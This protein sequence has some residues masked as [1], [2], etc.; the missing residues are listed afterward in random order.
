MNRFVK[1]IEPS[2]IYREYLTSLNGLLR[3][4]E[5]ELDILAKIIELNPSSTDPEVYANV[6][7]LP[8]R[9]KVI[10]DAKVNK[11]NLSKHITNFTKRG[12]L[13]KDNITG[14]V[15]INKALVP[16]IENGVVTIQMIIRLDETSTSK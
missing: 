1:Q 8:V 13:I 5:K 12:Y 9:R 2:N 11:A 6:V 3:L 14:S 7:S 10:K 15:V 4:T 16:I